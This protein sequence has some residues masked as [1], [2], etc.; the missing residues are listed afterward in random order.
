MPGSYNK[1]KES[2]GDEG[3][4]LF[5]DYSVIAENEVEWYSSKRGCTH[6]YGLLIRVLNAS[7]L[8]EL[9]EF[10]HLSENSEFRQT[11][12]HSL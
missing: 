10:F 1:R 11:L 6:P 3:T 5:D 9:N 2:E 4:K 7:N 12:E 8:D